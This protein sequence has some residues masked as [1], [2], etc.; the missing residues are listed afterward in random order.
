MAR[1]RRSAAQAREEILD[2]AEELLLSSGPDGVRLRAVADA[3]GMSHP[4]VLHHFGS[5]EVLLQGLHHRTS[6]RVREDLLALLSPVDATDADLYTAVDAAF[7]RMSDPRQGR[8]MAWVLASGIDPFPPAQERGLEVVAT[9]L[10]ERAGVD[11]DADEPRFVVMLGVLAMFG[12]ALVGAAVRQRLGLPDDDE[13][14]AR[15]RAWM[16]RVLGRTLRAR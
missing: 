5:V 3:V 10:G 16:Q 13:T 15:F 2:A 7:A 14:A 11:A 12:D 6:R 8:L 9:R 4:G 1:R